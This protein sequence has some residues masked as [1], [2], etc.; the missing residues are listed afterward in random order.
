MKGSLQYFVHVCFPDIFRGF[1]RVFQQAAP[2]IFIV[3]L[4]LDRVG[5]QIVSF[6]NFAKSDG[7][8]GRIVFVRMEFRRLLA[9]SVFYNGRRR[10]NFYAEYSVMILHA[11]FN[12]ITLAVLVLRPTSGLMTQNLQGVGCEIIHYYSSEVDT[13]PRLG[14]F[15]MFNASLQAAPAHAS[16]VASANVA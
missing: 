10:I 8:I 4:P 5:Q 16:M 15:N 1:K 6:L 12:V 13:A 9:I 14:P 3:G 11:V 7:G 2:A